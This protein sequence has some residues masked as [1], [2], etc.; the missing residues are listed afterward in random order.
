M[1]AALVLLALAGCSPSSGGVGEVVIPSSVISDSIVL[2]AELEDDYEAL[3]ALL[4]GNES[5]RRLY[6]PDVARATPL[7]L[8]RAYVYYNM[9]SISRGSRDPDDL[10]WIHTMPG[11]QHA[12]DSTI[13]SAAQLYGFTIASQEYDDWDPDSYG[14]QTSHY[15]LRCNHALS[16]GEIAWAADQIFTAS[17]DQIVYIEPVH[18]I[19]PAAIQP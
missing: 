1:L 12:Y 4:Q 15:E 17:S 8:R 3:G 11:G 19:Y 16:V 10:I 9:K 6:Q 18:Y 13:Q 5:N 14:Y 7:G 2:P